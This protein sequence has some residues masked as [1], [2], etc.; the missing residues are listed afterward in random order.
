MVDSAKSPKI[1]PKDLETPTLKTPVVTTG[2]GGSGNM[3]KNTDPLE[4]RL[5]QDVE[6]IQRRPSG[7]ATHI[8]R[9]GTGNVFKAGSEDA[10]KAKHAQQH[11]HNAVAEDKEEGLAAKGRN[12]L[13]GKKQH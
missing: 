5:R 4:T 10:E 11:D 8:G 6:P 7:G 9:G 13:F 1:E 3:A 2:R 12:F